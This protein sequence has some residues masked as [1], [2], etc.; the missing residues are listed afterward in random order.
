MGEVR[1]FLFLHFCLPCGFGAIYVPLQLLP[2]L[3]PSTLC[4]VLPLE[5]LVEDFMRGSGCD[6][7]PGCG[8]AHRK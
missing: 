2:L 1:G 3:G 6:F 7:S 8:T 5:D 4:A